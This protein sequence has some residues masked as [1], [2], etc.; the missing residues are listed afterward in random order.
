VLKNKTVST[1]S[2]ELELLVGKGEP[3]WG[4]PQSLYLAWQGFPTHRS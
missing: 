3:F 2:R 4:I 1:D